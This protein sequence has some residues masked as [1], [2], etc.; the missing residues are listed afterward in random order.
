MTNVFELL[1]DVVFVECWHVAGVMFQR[2]DFLLFFCC[3]C[4][5]LQRPIGVEW[6]ERVRLCVS[7]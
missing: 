7:E 5:V 2:L 1:I 4:F 3:F 6:W